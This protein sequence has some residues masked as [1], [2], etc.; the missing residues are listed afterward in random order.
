MIDNWT[1]HRLI[2]TGLLRPAGSFELPR[3]LP[4]EGVAVVPLDDLGRRTAAAR[5]A[6]GGF[7]RE[8]DRDG[9]S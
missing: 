7:D 3:P 2:E 8:F 1:R 9:R 5:V 6:A 4:L